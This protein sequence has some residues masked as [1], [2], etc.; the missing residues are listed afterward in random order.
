MAVAKAHPFIPGGFQTPTFL[1]WLRRTHAWLGVSGAFLGILFGFSTLQ[2]EHDN[3]GIESS[4]STT[5]TQMP[6]PAN[7]TGSIEE[8]GT[9]VSEQLGVGDDWVNASRNP[10]AISDDEYAIRF[11]SVGREY[12]ARFELGS[13]TAQ[14]TDLN[15]DFLETLVRLH[16]AEGVNIPWMIFS[17]AFTGALVVLSLTGIML[18]TRLHGGR[19]LAVGLLGTGILI[20]VYVSV[21]GA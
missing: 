8:F 17:D 18:W 20:A 2:M 1:K 19:L 9:Y 7:V 10:A 3:L 14:I 16:R 15:R 6:I 21:V 13:E 11:R 12:T 5:V 4:T